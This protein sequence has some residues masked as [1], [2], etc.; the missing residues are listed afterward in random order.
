MAALA[1]LTQ[2]VFDLR[3]GS[4][5]SVTKVRIASAS[6]TVDLPEGL[7]NAA[8]IKCIPVDS[9]DTAATATL[10]QLAHPQGGRVTLASGTLSSLQYVVALHSGNSAGL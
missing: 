10:S 5:L 4:W 9:A 1:P 6:D 3:G 7:N 8:H 2:E